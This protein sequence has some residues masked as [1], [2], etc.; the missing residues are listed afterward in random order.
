MKKE[1]ILILIF[2][3]GISLVNGNVGAGGAE[4]PTV[5]LLPFLVEKE[6]DSEAAS[7]CPICG[8]VGSRG[9]LPLGSESILTRLFYEKVEERKTFKVIPVEEVR[10]A[11][12]HIEREEIEASPVDFFLRLG[13]KMNADFVFIGFLFRFEERIGS[14][15]GAKRPASVGFDLHLFRCRDGK[16]VWE[17]RFH[18][19]QRPLSENLFRIFSFFRR[20]GYWLTAEALASI[21]MKEMLRRLPSAIELEEMP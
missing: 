12:K 18:E 14:P 9:A 6:E 20:G 3:V 8:R 7:I 4:R 15:L 11:L 10:E 2:L 13:R 1:F 16:M 19:T 21:G 5:A 17:A